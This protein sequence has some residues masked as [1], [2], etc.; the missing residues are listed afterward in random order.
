MFVMGACS[1]PHSSISS[2][3]PRS[4]SL[5]PQN[6]RSSS[7]AAAIPRTFADRGRTSGRSAGSATVARTR[8]LADLRLCRGPWSS[9]I[10]CTWFFSMTCVAA[11]YRALSSSTLRCNRRAACRALGLPVVPWPPDLPAQLLRLFASAPRAAF[12]CAAKASTGWAVPAP[13]TAR[14]DVR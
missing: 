10:A 7:S 6:T 13:R 12:T 11:R 4:K 3:F 14:M 2:W 9:Q 1:V 8:H 5:K